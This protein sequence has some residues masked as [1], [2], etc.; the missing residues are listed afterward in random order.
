MK[1]ENASARVPKP[2]CPARGPVYDMLDALADEHYRDRETIVE[3]EDG[4]VLP[5]AVPRLSGTPAAIRR[6][7]PALGEHNAEVYGELGL[8]DQELARLADEGVL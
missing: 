3:M 4:V 6:S 7:A 1:P 5:N 8:A 2:G